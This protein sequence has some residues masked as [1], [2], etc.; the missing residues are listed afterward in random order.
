MTDVSVVLADMLAR[1]IVGKCAVGGASAT[2]FYVE[3]IATKELETIPEV[4]Q[5][6]AWAQESRKK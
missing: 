4:W 3:P 5:R 6:W 2:A 1:G